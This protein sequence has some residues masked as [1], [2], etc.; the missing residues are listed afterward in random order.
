MKNKLKVTTVSAYALRAY[1]AIRAIVI[2]FDV[3]FFSF[4]VYYLITLEVADVGEGGQSKDVIFST[5]NAQ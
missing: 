2:G 3:F 5:R 4:D 1:T